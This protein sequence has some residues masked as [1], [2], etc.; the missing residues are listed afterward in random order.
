MD[1]V[2]STR[3]DEAAEAQIERFITQ[4]DE[5]RRQTEGERLEEEL[6]EPSVRRYWERHR[7]ERVAAW[8]AYF[9]QQADAHRKLSESYEARAE[10][11]CS[12]AKEGD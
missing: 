11:L 5:R 2:A 1:T 10:A 8:F 6:Y 4:R 9:C 7:R 3:S 12:E